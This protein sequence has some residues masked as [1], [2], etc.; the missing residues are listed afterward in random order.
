MLICRL[1]PGIRHVTPRNLHASHLSESIVIHHQILCAMKH[2]HAAHL[3]LDMDTQCPQRLQNQD[4]NLHARLL[5]LS[6]NNIA[7]IS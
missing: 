4:N 3:K 6:V 2:T 5:I 1:N 7:C